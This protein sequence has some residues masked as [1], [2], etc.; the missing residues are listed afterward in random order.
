[1]HYNHQ[2]IQVRNISIYFKTDLL[3]NLVRVSSKF[4]FNSF[5]LLLSSDH[6]A[7]LNVGFFTKSFC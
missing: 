2:V 1:M 6:D 5:P 3:L 4:I 7:S